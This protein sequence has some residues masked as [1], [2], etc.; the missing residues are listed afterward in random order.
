V[1][2]F[3]TFNGNEGLAMPFYPIP[4]YSQA[5]KSTG[6]EYFLS[7]AFSVYIAPKF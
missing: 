5:L 3:H 2:R 7:G 4:E 6:Q 1:V